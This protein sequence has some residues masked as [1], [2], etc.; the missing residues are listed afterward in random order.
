MV[1]CTAAIFFSNG[2]FDGLVFKC[3]FGAGESIFLDHE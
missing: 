1:T 3:G 2:G